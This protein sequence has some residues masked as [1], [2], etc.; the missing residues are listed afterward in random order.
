MLEISDLN[1]SHGKVPVLWEVALSVDEGKITAIVG[2]NGSGKT[3]LLDTIIG[4]LKPSSGAIKFLD[5]D[6]TKLPSHQ[7]V[8]VGIALVPEGRMLFTG[9]TVEEN[10]R[11]GSYICRDNRK[12]IETLN[13]VYK[14]FPILK[15]RKKQLAGTLSGGEQQMLAISRGL[16]S[17]PKLLMLDEPSSG[18]APLLVSMVFE[19]IERINKEG[20]TVLL[21]EQ[22]VRK[23][24][25]ICDQAYVLVTG[26]IAKRGMGKD[27]LQD[28][29]IRKYYLAL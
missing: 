16:M 12:R 10:L 28:D 2:S 11:M 24:L 15:E 26:R 3:T 9:L 8:E 29:Q 22:N 19:I 18:L 7:R 21:V 27:L 20:I 17:R 13:W 4:L 1:V 23:S 14:I 25:D 5:K 6:I